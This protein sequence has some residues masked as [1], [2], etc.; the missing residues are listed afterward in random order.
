MY[1][2]GKSLSMYVDNVYAK[3]GDV[4]HGNSITL[5]G[6]CVRFETH[7]NQIINVFQHQEAW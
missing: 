5:Q 6:I 3:K 2:L 1:E 4:F 7:A